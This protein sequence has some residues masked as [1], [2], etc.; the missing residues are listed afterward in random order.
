MTVVPGVP[1]RRSTARSAELFDAA[2]RVI[3]G[4]VNSPVRAFRGVG[5][6][7]RFVVRGDGARITDTD[8]H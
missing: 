5:G 3:P 6:T 2:R 7:P 8:G 1:V 4:G